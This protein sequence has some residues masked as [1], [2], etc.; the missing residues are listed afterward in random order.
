MPAWICS[1]TRA[2]TSAS[3]S[4]SGSTFSRVAKAALMSADEARPN[5]FI[6]D[7]AHRT[8]ITLATQPISLGR[9]GAATCYVSAFELR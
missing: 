6:N 2:T 5:C 4:A 3:R 9:S 1:S 8:Q 7:Q